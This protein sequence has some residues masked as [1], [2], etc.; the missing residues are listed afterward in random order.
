MVMILLSHAPR[1]LLLQLRVRNAAIPI[2]R[3][4]TRSCMRVVHTIV[5]TTMIYST[6]VVRKVLRAVMLL[7]RRRVLMQLVL[8]GMLAEVVSGSPVLPLHLVHDPRVDR[9]LDL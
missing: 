1:Q 7:L 4:G 8:D 3:L 2:L 5:V 9:H 6:R